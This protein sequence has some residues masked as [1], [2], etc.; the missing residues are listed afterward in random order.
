MKHYKVRL[1]P[2]AETDLVHIH[3]HVETRSASTATADRYIERIA[4]FLSSFDMYPERG[5]V[6]DEVRP[7]LRV[8]G[9]ERNISVA[10]I[11][12]AYDVVILRILAG[13]QEFSSSR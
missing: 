12:E 8:V 11:V 10:F 9:F 4:G 7:G 6:R 13:G 1:S 2:E 3:D 5:T